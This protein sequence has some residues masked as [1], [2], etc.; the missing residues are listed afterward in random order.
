MHKIYSWIQYRME[1]YVDT[2]SPSSLVG[3]AYSSW[4]QGNRFKPLMRCQIFFW[5][6]YYHQF[7]QSNTCIYKNS[8]GDTTFMQKE[9]KYL[10]YYYSLQSFDHFCSLKYC[11]DTL[12]YLKICLYPRYLIISWYS[13]FKKIRIRNKIDSYKLCMGFQ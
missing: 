8:S 7:H 4:S 13:N 1:L 9:F 6:F 12:R 5:W 3:R 2:T 11:W 10:G